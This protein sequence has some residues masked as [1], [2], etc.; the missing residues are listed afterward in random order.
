M[1]TQDKWLLVLR[2]I[3]L[4]CIV[5]LTALT[6][7]MIVSPGVRAPLLTMMGGATIVIT[8]YPPRVSTIPEIAQ[9]LIALVGTGIAIAGAS[10]WLIDA[11]Q[12]SVGDDFRVPF[13]L[14]AL[15]MFLVVLYVVLSILILADWDGIKQTL[16]VAVRKI[17]RR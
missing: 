1:T 6:V 15:L 13:S 5:T 16:R 8:L 11:A 14:A 10:N 7:G 12:E 17:M 4:A 9:D 3:V 2:I